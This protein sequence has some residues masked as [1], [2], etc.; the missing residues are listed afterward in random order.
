MESSNLR[1]VVAKNREYIL[2]TEMVVE[3]IA[4]KKTAHMRIGEKDLE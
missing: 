2:M 4:V 3:Y 1:V